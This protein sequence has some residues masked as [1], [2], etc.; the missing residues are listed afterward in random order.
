MLVQLQQCSRLVVKRAPVQRSCK[1]KGSLAA[2]PPDESSGQCVWEEI[3]L[4][5]LSLTTTDSEN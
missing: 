1:P 4:H 2:L 5:L 3:F